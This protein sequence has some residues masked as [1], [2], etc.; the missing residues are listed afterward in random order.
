VF[1]SQDPADQQ[2]NKGMA[3][4]SGLT[5]SKMFFNEDSDGP[6]Q[7]KFLE[8][9]ESKMFALKEE[10]ESN[11]G[12]IANN[13]DLQDIVDDVFETFTIFNHIMGDIYSFDGSNVLSGEQWWNFYVKPNFKALSLDWKQP[14]PAE[15]TVSNATFNVTLSD[16]DQIAEFQ[17]ITSKRPFRA[18]KINANGSNVPDGDTINTMYSN[19]DVDAVRVIGIMAYEMGLDPTEYPEESEIAITQKAFLQQL[20]DTYEGRLYYVT[21]TRFGNDNRKDPYG[22]ALGWLYVENGLDGD[23]ADGT[24]EY[25]FFSDHFSPADNYYNINSEEP[26]ISGDYSTD[27]DNIK[28]DLR[29]FTDKI[30]VENE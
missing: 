3:L 18:I 17:T 1:S 9:F 20:V 22:R 19:M 5:K 2:F 6:E 7:L 8:R 10:W 29:K 24:G 14:V 16:Q 4:L 23:L 25:V 26:S 12:Q 21:D 28:W 13:D 11:D 30:E 27:K 15:G